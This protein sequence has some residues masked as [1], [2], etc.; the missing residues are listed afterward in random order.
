[1]H[2]RARKAVGCAGLLIY[3]AVYAV[4][5]ATLG[6]YLTTILPAWAELVF[7]AI[8]GIIWIFPLK[9]LFAWMNQGP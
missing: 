1:M 8:A 6:A 3:L 7:F 5:A 4:L 2:I 9:P